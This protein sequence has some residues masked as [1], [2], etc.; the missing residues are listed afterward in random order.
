MLINIHSHHHALNNSQWVIKNVYEGFKVVENIGIY[1]IGL[2]PW[3]VNKNTWL[4]QFEFLKKYADNNF[5]VAIGEC[6]LDKNCE[7]D[8]SLQTEIFLAH[9]H[10][11]NKLKKPLI[12]HC[13]NAYDEV[14]QILKKDGNA[15]PVIFHG[16]NK[17][18][19]IALQLVNEGY[20]LSF[21]KAI[22]KKNIQAIVGNAPIEN[23]FF[24]TDDD[25]ISIE[26]IYVEAEKILKM[27]CFTLEL[28]IQ[29]N[30]I[31]IFGDGIF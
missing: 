19:S 8:F 21:G 10:L 4:T 6:G 29:K 14:I 18:E 12:I 3:Y 17:K 15:V 23:V 16:F 11:A 5:V 26:E 31:K 28:Q 9:I 7:T 20:F 30:A 27:D 1:S 25:K 22:F 2:H 24:E 13:V